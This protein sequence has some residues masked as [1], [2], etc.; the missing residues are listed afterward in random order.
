MCLVHFHG[1][2]AQTLM[3][4]KRSFVSVLIAAM[5]HIEPGQSHFNFR[6]SRRNFPSSADEYENYFLCR[7]HSAQRRSNNQV[8]FDVLLKL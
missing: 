3:P 7:L 1:R 8:K 5:P 2:V 6:G 4:D